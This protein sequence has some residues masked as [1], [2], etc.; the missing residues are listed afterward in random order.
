M[1]PKELAT[2][3]RVL[4]QIF[5]RDVEGSRGICLLDRDV[6]TAK[7]KARLDIALG[8]IRTIGADCLKSKWYLHVGQSAH[9]KSAPGNDD[10][11]R[12]ARLFGNLP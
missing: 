7:P 1:N 6:D 10:R 8:S 2:R 4:G 12:E 5:G 9:L 11:R 3:L